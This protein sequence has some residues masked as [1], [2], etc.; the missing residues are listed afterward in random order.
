[1]SVEGGRTLIM[2]RTGTST[3][4]ATYHTTPARE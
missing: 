3:N 1:V 2:E 4:Q